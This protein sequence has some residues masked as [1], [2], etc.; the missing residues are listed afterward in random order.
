MTKLCLGDGH[1]FV[2]LTFLN[3][4]AALTIIS[5]YIKLGP[6]VKEFCKNLQNLQNL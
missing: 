2:D 3:I 1:V 6:V 5:I 4:L